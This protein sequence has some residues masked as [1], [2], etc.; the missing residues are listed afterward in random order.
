MQT[1]IRPS[2]KNGPRPSS[3]GKNGDGAL[4]CTGMRP[5]GTSSP[6]ARAAISIACPAAPAGSGT[7]AHQPQRSDRSKRGIRC[8]A[9]RWRWPPTSSSSS[10][11]PGARPSRNRADG[12]PGGSEAG[13]SLSMAT[14]AGGMRGG[15]LE[16][17]AMIA[18]ACSVTDV[19]MYD[20]AAG[21]GIELAKE[22]DS[23]V[24]A[25]AAAGSIFRSY[26][27]ILDDAAKLEDLEA[28]VLV[29]QDAELTQADT[30]AR[31]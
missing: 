2:C 19:P 31:I 17:L 16:S 30:C 15:S 18:F 11:T 21:P 23:V 3:C 10:R 1:A 24:L 26:N 20:R 5:S 12:R 8:A 9:G 27:L 29:H 14:S 4:S 22:P 25:R 7:T 13:S 28:L 6:S